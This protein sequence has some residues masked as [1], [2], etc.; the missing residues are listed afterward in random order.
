MKKFNLLFFIFLGA[1]LLSFGG[2]FTAKYYGE[3]KFRETAQIYLEQSGL[4]DKVKVSEYEYNPLTGVGALK[5]IEIR[6]YSTKEY[7]VN[8]IKKIELRKYE[9]DKETDIPLKADIAVYGISVHIKKDGSKL[10]GDVFSKYLYDPEKAKLEL[11]NLEVRF[12]D[13]FDVK[14]AFTIGNISKDLM[15]KLVKLGKERPSNPHTGDMMILYSKLLQIKPEYFHF[16][17][18]EQG[19]INKLIENDARKKGL[20]PE[21][22]KKRIIKDLERSKDKLKSDFEKKFVNGF[23]YMVQEGRGKFVVDIKA[24]KDV[25]LQDIIAMLMKASMTG[26]SQEEKAKIFY[27]TFSEYFDLKFDFVEES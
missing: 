7:T 22:L 8:R 9:L 16:E 27:E 11:K 12:R 13:F 3:K 1:V 5:D 10:V 21:D 24:K 4:G 19:M 23:M 25:T 26:S 17:Y 18:A 6:D 2:Y 20:K 14:T 15:E